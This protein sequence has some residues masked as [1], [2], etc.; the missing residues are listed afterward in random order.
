MR[1]VRTR[2]AWSLTIPALVL[3]ETFGHAFVTRIFDPH[4]E[5]H[6]LLARTA[7]DYLTYLYAAI[8]ICFALALAALVRRAFASFHGRTGRTL[9]SWQLAGVPSVA[10]IAQE[11]LESLLHNGELNWLTF[12]EPT[13]LL[14][15]VMQLPCGLLA[16][17][18]V[19]TLIRAADELGQAL[20]RCRAERRIRHRPALAICHGR[21]DDALRLL[22]LVRGLGERAPPSFA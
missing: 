13:V 2:T 17:W 7:E 1:D 18:L 4:S 21:Q 14:G 3:G 11:H 5:R 12:A 10:F 20:S 15:A 19:R 6:Q 22:A 8:A 9:P 16:L